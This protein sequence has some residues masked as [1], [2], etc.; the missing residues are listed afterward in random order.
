MSEGVVNLLRWHGTVT[1]RWERAW[2]FERVGIMDGPVTWGVRD[3]LSSG[4]PRSGLIV[5]S[6]VYGALLTD[7]RF[8]GTSS[9][10]RCP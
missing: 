8:R 4:V 6:L 10:L 1:R 9:C 3:H 2:R 7:A 5:R